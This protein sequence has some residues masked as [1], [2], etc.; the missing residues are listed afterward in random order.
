MRT[1]H[2][3]ERRM[4][5]RETETLERHLEAKS[6]CVARFQEIR[7]EQLSRAERASTL[8][9]LDGFADEAA[10]GIDASAHPI[11]TAA[12]H[13]V[14]VTAALLSLAAM[15]TT[16]KF[17]QAQIL[18]RRHLLH[19]LALCPTK[20]RV[21]SPEQ[22]K[23]LSARLLQ[24]IGE[25]SSQSG[26]FP[27]R[28]QPDLS[29]Q[30]DEGSPSHVLQAFTHAFRHLPH[31]SLR[32]QE[33]LEGLLEELSRL[34]TCRKDLGGY[35]SR[36]TAKEAAMEEK[37][38]ALLLP[39][40]EWG[41]MAA[42]AM[43]CDEEKHL[44]ISATFTTS[45]LITR[46]KQL[47]WRLAELQAALA[48][49]IV[50]HAMAMLRK[51]PQSLLTSNPAAA[52]DEA[53]KE[54]ARLEQLHEQL[55]LE[56][57]FLRRK[58][59]TMVDQR[60]W[61][62][63]LK[64][65]TAVAPRGGPEPV[66]P[67]LGMLGGL[68]L[69]EYHTRLEGFLAP[70]SSVDRV[71]GRDSAPPASS[72]PA[73]GTLLS[74]GP[75][76]PTPRRPPALM[77]SMR[78][79]W[80]REQVESHQQS[81]ASLLTTNARLVESISSVRMVYGFA[82]EPEKAGSLVDALLTRCGFGLPPQ[83]YLGGEEPNFDVAPF[84]SSFLTELQERVLEKY[85]GRLEAVQAGANACLERLRL[86]VQQRD[87]YWR[88]NLAFILRIQ[89]LSDLRRLTTIPGRHSEMVASFGEVLRRVLD[90]LES[91]E[92]PSVSHPVGEGE[93]SD[94]FRI[95]ALPRSLKSLQKEFRTLHNSK[96]DSKKATW[97]AH[98]REC[99]AKR[100]ELEWY[101]QFTTEEIPDALE[102]ARKV[103]KRLK[104]EILSVQ[105]SRELLHINKNKASQLDKAFNEILEQQKNPL[106]ARVDELRAQLQRLQEENKA[107]MAKTWVQTTPVEQ[108]GEVVAAPSL[109]DRSELEWR[110]SPQANPVGS[111][112]SHQDEQY[113]NDNE[114]SSEMP[115][116]SY[117]DTTQSPQDNEASVDED[118]GFVQN[119][120]YSG[121]Y[122][123]AD[124]GNE[125]SVMTGDHDEELNEEAASDP[126][127]FPDEPFGGSEGN[128]ATGHQE[129]E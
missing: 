27:A 89:H 49:L 40:Q 124:V 117:H 86:E 31:P 90:C 67:P 121:G 54:A 43:L 122:T 105:R 15:T 76:L 38:K 25:G 47:K 44:Y 64:D 55:V 87:P 22:V 13:D 2:A 14:R 123:H 4:A 102:E 30:A 81:L 45:P 115:T 60:Y 70:S 19:D 51:E 110:S 69:S 120:D 80:L 11:L 109:I 82:V 3:F 46:N 28:T 41:V 71:E 97:V 7:R 6:R 84:S 112:S 101:E 17:Q 116:H 94:A 114:V 21:D 78:L 63:A 125:E 103:Q 77:R 1:R 5:E 93:I 96:V 56:V 34:S 65:A 9:L 50:A 119:A 99:A 127:E 24:S 92:K 37:L 16:Y 79:L 36:Q 104:Q 42:Q 83:N 108:P 73:G 95:P 128:S 18:K 68:L 91:N 52:A 8:P 126:L 107:A 59:R 33:A 74:E 88:G 23:Q 100:E 129:T 75:S 32:Q 106:R 62:H 72:H 29:T 98:L 113:E 85:R 26:C 118:M 10:V 53:E 35:C 20:S 39:T 57:M 66:N 58:L 48:S 12:A 111:G 61:R